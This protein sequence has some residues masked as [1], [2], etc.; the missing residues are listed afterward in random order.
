MRHVHALRVGP[1]AFRVGSDWRAPV[2]ALADLYRGYPAPEGGIVDYSVRLFAAR[3]WRRLIRPAITLGGD[4]RLPDALPLPLRLGLLAAEMAMNLQVALGERR[5]LLLHASVVERG[6]RALIMSGAS[7]SG[8]STLAALL[9]RKGWRLLGD[10]FALIDPTTGLAQPF[11]RLV[12]LKNAAIA[13]LGHV[14]PAARLGPLLVGT[15]KGDIA[16]LVPDAE[17]IA[18]MDEPARPA[19][20]LFPSFGHA[21]AERPAPASEVFVRLTQSST[22]YTALGEAG[23]GALTRLATF[24]SY[25][26]D[27]PDTDAAVSRVEALWSAHA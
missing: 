22:N 13:E 9:S 14:D 17:S 7:G 10:E 18:R 2:A 3:P 19:L 8:K 4:Y 23:F 21:S 20:L 24:P 1:I 25:A 16:H 12:S 5:F 27:Y 11:P 6:G 15:P 26:I